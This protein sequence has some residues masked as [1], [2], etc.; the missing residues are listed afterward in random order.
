MSI[1]GGGVAPVEAAPDAAVGSHREVTFSLRPSTLTLPWNKGTIIGQRS[2]TPSGAAPW[3]PAQAPSVYYTPF[4]A[5]STCTAGGYYTLCCTTSIGGGATSQACSHTHQT[6]TPTLH[7][8]LPGDFDAVLPSDSGPEWLL[9]TPEMTTSSLRLPSQ[10][11]QTISTSTGALLTSKGEESS[12]EPAAN[13]SWMRMTAEG[14]SITGGPT[15][16]SPH[17][18]QSTLS[19]QCESGYAGS[20]P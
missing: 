2:I 17:H 20:S 15:Q 9:P 7:W 5:T 13:L 1:E 16:R 10:Q 18:H 14:G 8:L 11:L 4:C 12:F 6:C 3:L 19:F